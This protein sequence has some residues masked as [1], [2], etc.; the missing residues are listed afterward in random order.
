MGGANSEEETAG[1]T[2]ISGDPGIV[3]LHVGKAAYM[4]VNCC[5]AVCISLILR[6]V[7]AAK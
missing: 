6:D 2:P 1:A 3:S 4:S 7:V 5:V